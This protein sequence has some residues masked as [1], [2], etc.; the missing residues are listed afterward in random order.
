VLLLDEPLSNLDAKLREEMRLEI[1]QLVKSLGITTIYVTHDQVEAL[2]MS[3]RVAVM[4]EGL[5]QQEGTPREVYGTPHNVFTATFV[6][7]TNLLEGRVQG[8]KS[9]DKMTALETRLGTFLGLTP[10][11]IQPGE[12]AVLSVRPEKV[13][14][15][16]DPP[17]TDSDR[18]VV[19]GEVTV[20]VFCGDY[21][22]CEIRCGEQTVLAKLDPTSS[23]VDVGKSV[24]VHFPP[25]SCYIL[26]A[27]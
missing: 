7:K 4:N 19:R 27:D 22:Q 14:V 2:A 26:K 10:D 6:G 15:R 17:K 18:N 24:Y 5:L 23:S 9:R 21:L 20:A 8:E 25:E 1:K 16:A 13:V 12:A 3:D 11:G